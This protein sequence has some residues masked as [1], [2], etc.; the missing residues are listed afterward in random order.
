LVKSIQYRG[1]ET[2]TWTLNVATAGT[3]A[4]YARWTAHPNRASNAKYTVTHAAGPETVTINQ[5]ANS[6]SWQLIGTYSFNAGAATVSLSDEANGYVIADAVMLAPPG[7]AP[8]T[9]TWTLEV[10]AS[11]QY[12]VYAR[13]TQHPNRATNAPYTVNHAAGSTTVLVNQEQ[14]GNTW[15]LLGSFGFNAGAASVTLTDQANDYVIADAVMLLPPG[16]APNSATW[17]PNVAQAGQYEVYAR[18]TSHANRASNATY[19]VTHA[20]GATPVTVNQQ[21]GGGAWNLLGTF[22]LAPGSTHKVTLSDQAN[23]YVIADAIR[24]VPVAVQAQQKLYFVHVDHLNTPR[25][26]ADATGTTVWKWDQ[27]E[28]FGSNVA[29]GNPSGLGAFDLPLRLPGQYFD[30]ETNLH[31]NYYRDFDPSLGRYAESDPI[32]LRGGLNTYAYVSA[33]P[34]QLV[35]LFGLR[36]RVCCRGIPAT[37]NV[38]GHCYIETDNDGRTTFGLFGGP[39]TGMAAGVGQIFTQRGFDIG[40]SCGEW[41][42]DCGTDDC[43]KQAAGAYSNPSIYDLGGPNSNT[44][45]SNIAAKCKLKTPPHNYWTPGWG[46]VAAPP[47]PGYPQ[48]PINTPP[49]PSLPSWPDSSNP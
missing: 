7:A 1:A 9:V 31:Y 46:G 41:S 49:L 30:K 38:A 47:A 22:S 43:V 10:P 42:D 26:V 15:F 4:V 18:W 48:V 33:R 12:D 3:Y 37:L 6:A 16:A 11:S 32:G 40:G 29:D 13:W 27:Q 23:G 5:Q 28:P 44:F 19:T 35:D 2:F 21:S 20:G 36:S 25:L 24:L 8:N 14:G 39:G 34:L 17:T 45:A